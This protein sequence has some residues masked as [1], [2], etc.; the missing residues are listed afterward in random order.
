M[1]YPVQFLVGSEVSDSRVECFLCHSR[2]LVSNRDGL[3]VDPRRGALALSGFMQHLRRGPSVIHFFLTLYLA[4]VLCWAWI[5]TRF[6]TVLLPLALF[7]I[8]QGIPGVVRKQRLTLCAAVALPLALLAGSLQAAY[9]HSIQTLHTGI[10]MSEKENWRDMLQM[11]TWIREHTS[12]DTI[13]LGNI[14]PALYLYTDRKSIRGFYADPYLLFYSNPK[15]ANPLGTAAAFREA[16][17]RQGVSYIVT[18]PD[19]GFAEKPYLK[20]LI[21]ELGRSRPGALSVAYEGATT[22]YRVYRIDR[23]LCYP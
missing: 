13:L 15:G 1:E 23:A 19:Q 4:V 14:D 7:F 22:D 18:T 21:S 11:T 9:A 3:I 2:S 5:P 8:W 20:R 6:V 10:A 12:R 17:L 16:I